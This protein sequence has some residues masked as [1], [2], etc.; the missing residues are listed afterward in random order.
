MMGVNIKRLQGALE[1]IGAGMGGL[2][3]P[4]DALDA[5]NSGTTVRLMSGVLAAQGFTSRITGDDSLSKRPMKRIITPL[6]LMGAKLT[7]REGNFL[8]MA[9]EGNPGLK[10][11]NYKSPVASA[12]VKSCVLLAGMIA[13]GETVF[14]EPVKSRDHTERMMKAFGA[15][16]KVN[17]FTVSIT[18]P[19]K[20]K[21]LNVAVPG[22]I[23]S[24][25]FFLAA[26][27]LASNDGITLKNVGINPTRDGMLEV[28]GKMGAS[29]QISNRREVSGEPV[30]DITVKKSALRGTQITVEM[31]PRLIDEIPVI[32]LAATQAQGQT[33]ISGATELR[34][35]ESDRINTVLTALRKMGANVSETADGMVIEGP[36]PL[37]G[38]VIDSCGDHRLVM[39]AAIAGI[40]AGGAMKIRGADCVNTS[41]PEFLRDLKNIG[42]DCG[43]N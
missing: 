37:R 20:L 34:V 38:A 36:T 16:V 18:G 17:G 23:S 39:M 21:A 42:V 32:A 19:A 7:A 13:K 31:I 29:V 30:A 26:G 3:A 15:D 35:K 2:K 10:P 8:P 9:I 22:D 1:I 5:G 24:A 11:V 4:A 14:T 6:A 33:V 28:L 43:A 12:Q 25:A 27:C 41:Y 40:I